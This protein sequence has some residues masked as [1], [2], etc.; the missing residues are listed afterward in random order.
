[1][2]KR[3]VNHMNV[4]FFIC[5]TLAVLL[6]GCASVQFAPL[7]IVPLH[8]RIDSALEES[9]FTAE[10]QLS[11]YYISVHDQSDAWEL[12]D[13]D[14][15]LPTSFDLESAVATAINRLES[16]QFSVTPVYLQ[17]APPMNVYRLEIRYNG[18]L[19]GIAS[20]HQHIA[21][22]AAIVI[23][24][25]GHNTRALPAALS[26]NRPLTFAVLP[27]LPKSAHLA[28]VLHKNGQ[29]IMLHQPMAPEGTENPGPGAILAGMNAQQIEDVLS[30]NI[31]SIPYIAG[32]NNH[33]GSRITAD[34]H[35]MSVILSYLKRND[36]FFFDSLTGNSVCSS[37]AA[38]LDFPIYVRNTFIDNEHSK[39]YIHK[40]LDRLIYHALVH[41]TAI[42]IGHFYPITLECIYEK[43]PEL[44]KKK[45]KLV[46]IS[47]LK[48][49]Y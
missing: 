28:E 9:G 7:D 18:L 47:D 43:I 16:A 33:M 49:G 46:Y 29:L 34:K 41:G 44:D 3:T 26:I 2:I 15:Q 39:P 8:N 1:M 19:I 48:P 14:F 30:E 17:I 31:N 27:H 42:G 25:L 32:I 10:Y 12:L 38:E 13:T 5:I 45:V 36:L 20:F 11:A 24:D 6:N 23:D 37:V 4:I 21:G 35:A 22:Y 40:Q